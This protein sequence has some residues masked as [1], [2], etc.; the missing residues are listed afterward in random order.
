MAP[1]TKAFTFEF[2]QGFHEVLFV[3]DPIAELLDAL[4]PSSITSNDKRIAPL[5]LAINPDIIVVL[6]E[7]HYSGARRWPREEVVYHRST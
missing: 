1:A 4:F 6:F 2:M 3:D 7:V 5:G